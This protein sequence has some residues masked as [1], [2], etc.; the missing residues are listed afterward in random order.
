MK[1]KKKWVKDPEALHEALEGL[2]DHYATIANANH[3]DP[4]PSYFDGV[5]DG[6]NKAWKL[7]FGIETEKQLKA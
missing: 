3:E 1:I 7:I 4:S 2:L 6:V 5:T